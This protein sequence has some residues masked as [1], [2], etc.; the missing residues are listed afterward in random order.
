M[1]HLSASFSLRAIPLALLSLSISASAFASESALRETVVTA[2]RHATDIDSINATVST[3]DRKAMDR[4]LPADEADLLR[5]DPDVIMARDMRRHGATRINI[6]GIEDNRVVQLVDGVR[7]GDFFNG[8]GPT[9]YTMNAVGGPSLDFLRKV[10]IVRGPA[11]SMY[12]SDALGGVVGYLTL[13]PEDIVQTGNRTGLR[14][15]GTYL[16]ASSTL[17]GS[18]IA[19]YKGD[20]IDLLLGYSQAKGEETRNK[21]NNGTYGPDRTK[22]NPAEIEDRGAIAKLIVRPASGHKLTGM[23]EGREQE[24]NTEIMRVSASMPRVTQMTG[25]DESR[26]VRGSLEYEHAAQG[27]IYDRLTARAYHQV[28]ET[29]NA[30]RQI[31]SNARYST[32]TGCSASSS[33]APTA[34]CDIA[35]NFFFDQTTSGAGLQ[36]ESMFSLGASSHLLSYGIDMMRQRVESK[37]D[38]TVLNMGN[39]VTTYGLAGE[40]YPLRDFANGVTDT[41]GI[42]I[43]DEI[44]LLNKRLAITPGLR[45]DQTKLKPEV[46]ALAQQ[47]LT[48]INR[49]AVSQE[50]SHLSP[51]IGAQW[52]FDPA[53]TA[54][55]QIAT[56]FRAPN[57]T[58]VN[59]AFRNSAQIYATSP[60]P[61]LKPET[62]IGAELG[63][64]LRTANLSGQFAVFDNRYKDFIDNVRLDCPADP[65][66]VNIG[67][68]PYTTYMSRNLSNV[69]IWG[70]ETKAAWEL[71]RNWRIDGALAYAHGENTETGQPINSVEPLRASLGLNFDSGNWGSE[72]RIRAAQ[73]KKRVDDSGGTFFK[74]PGYAVTDISVW[75]KPTRNTQI[76]AAVSNLFDQ[77]YWLWGDIRQ[78]DTSL[79]GV[80]FYTQ[81]GR[82]FRLSLQADF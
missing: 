31:R 77:K 32:A 7:L 4:R 38:G 66:C 18:A 81:S 16:G 76:V 55:G 35:Q 65:K 30:N 67:G 43:Q 33:T 11:S 74:T 53:L 28:S 39:G 41:L 3:V 22:P 29:H 15:K 8:G 50:H 62:S 40:T 58:E 57:Y 9:N 25:N 60:N 79:R 47:V 72:G 13:N 45:Y 14:I 34:N 48:T 80:D 52:R 23:L 56:G 82:N 68:T 10:E 59:G 36:F 42:Y 44:E 6:R 21:G 64:R 12:G 54:F 20:V 78:A 37:R 17:S 26:R 24:A 5:D 51:K 71:T 2:N 75:F 69:R 63:L 73:G 19:A 1:P 49:Q 61:D 70:A 46:D 27:L